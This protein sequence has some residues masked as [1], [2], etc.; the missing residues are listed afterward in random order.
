MTKYQDEGDAAAT[1]VD[2]WNRSCQKRAAYELSRGKVHATLGKCGDFL[3]ILRQR[4]F[5][6]AENRHRIQEKIIDLECE[7]WYLK[8]L[9]FTT[10]LLR[11]NTRKLTAK[12]FKLDLKSMCMEY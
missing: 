10:K 8:T 11:E 9:T 3:R 5:L 2:N 7:G 4:L 1:R 12:H 6:L